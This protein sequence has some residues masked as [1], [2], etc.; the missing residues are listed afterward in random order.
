[1]LSA[2]GQRPTPIALVTAVALASTTALLLVV[3]GRRKSS[4]APDPEHEQLLEILAELSKKFFNTCQD[5]YQLAK[6]VR[7]KMQSSGVTAS[8]DTLNQQLLRQSK[9]F[10]KLETITAEVAAKFG[11]TSAEIQDM[12]T[13]AARDP[14]VRQYT[15]GF[16]Q[17]LSDAV[18]GMPPILPNATIPPALT[19]EKVLQIQGEAQILEASKIKDKVGRSKVEWSQLGEVLKTAHTD[20]W[21][22][23]LK[24]YA[25]EVQG[26]PEL[27]HSAVATYMRNEDFAKDRNALHEQH[28]AKMVKLFKPSNGAKTK[29]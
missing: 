15:E 3:L 27:Y 12:Q 29:N 19:E 21:D 23:T 20:A 16:Q 13:R 8:E 18:A 24:I 4:K 14:V 10:E 1:M 25:E 26:S 28:Q 2:G 5:L 17:M 22:E 7:E 11:C 6:S 9:V